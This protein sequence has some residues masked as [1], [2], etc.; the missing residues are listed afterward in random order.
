MA[1]TKHV[2]QTPEEVAHVWAN[3]NRDQCDNPHRTDSHYKTR[4]G[5]CYSEGGTIYSYGSHF[6]IAVHRYKNYSEGVQRHVVLI[7]TRTYSKTTSGHVWAVQR[8]CR[9]LETI[10]VFNPLAN[11]ERAHRENLEDIAEKIEAAQAKM[12]KARTRKSEYAGQ[13]ASL[14]ANAKAYAAWFDLDLPGEESIDA[15][16]AGI[17][18]LRQK[19]EENERRRKEEEQRRLELAFAEKLPSW[20][21][22]KLSTHD[23]PYHVR[24]GNGDGLA[25]LRIC[26]DAPDDVETSQWATVPLSSVQA[27]WPLYRAYR[28][29]DHE[30]QRRAYHKMLG[31]HLGAFSVSNITATGL[32]VGCHLFTHEEIERFA[33]VI[34][35][36]PLGIAPQGWTHVETSTEDMDT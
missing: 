33:A 10:H 12:T 14:I 8:A 22:G 7:T 21:A 32:H 17:V 25:Y 29:G 6:P 30:T 19:H 27:F 34:D 16:L 4:S 3:L 15:L 9:H 11:D 28:T 5:S 20:L 26:P 18:A 36:P 2:F 31:R 13:I 24:S 1:R 35:L 23:L